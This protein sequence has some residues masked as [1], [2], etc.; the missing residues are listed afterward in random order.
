MQHRV[1]QINTTDI[2]FL[3]YVERDFKPIDGLSESDS[4]SIIHTAY[5]TLRESENE[6]RNNLKLMDI[7]LA[8]LIMPIKSLR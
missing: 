7:K 1:M 8:D 3:K 5:Q 6:I 2:S 4:A